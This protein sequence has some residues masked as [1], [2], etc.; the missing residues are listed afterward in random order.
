MRSNI[1]RSVLTTSSHVFVCQWTEM[2]GDKKM[3]EKTCP[4]EQKLVLEVLCPNNPFR[5]N[6]LTHPITTNQ[7]TSLH[8][9]L[10]FLIFSLYALGLPSTPQSYPLRSAST[11]TIALH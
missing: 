3:F 2:P 10:S 7:T 4:H 1:L 8:L 9:F 5:R 11:H 6:L